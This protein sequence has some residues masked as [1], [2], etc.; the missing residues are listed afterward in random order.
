MT[1]DLFFI[2]VDDRFGRKFYFSTFTPLPLPS[3][4][5]C[6]QGG[7]Q[8]QDTKESDTEEYVRIRGELFCESFSLKLKKKKEGEKERE[9][10]GD[11][12][13]ERRPVLW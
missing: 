8:Q 13:R 1:V 2:I 3:Q 7:R 10:E 4:F 9:R 11:G 6:S 12:E 5:D